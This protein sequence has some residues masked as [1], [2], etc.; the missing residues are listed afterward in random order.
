VVLK[1]LKTRSFNKL[2]AHDQNWIHKLPSMLCSI[3]MTVTK[4]T[5]ENTL[6]LIYGAEAVLHAKLKNGSPRALAFSE[7][8]KGNIH[9]ENLLLLEEAG[10]R[11]VVRAARYQQGLRRYHGNNIRSR[12]LEAGDLVLRSI[13]SREV[14]HKISR[15]WEGPFRVTHIA[16]PG[17]ARL[18]KQKHLT[19]PLVCPRE[20]LVII[21]KTTGLSFAVERFGTLAAIIITIF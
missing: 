5:G 11:V 15:M 19:K 12:T 8:K 16:H 18:E 10:T 14:L 21:S 2:K 1:G 9:A 20:R 3:H 4:P 17:A 6:S 13:L 7:A